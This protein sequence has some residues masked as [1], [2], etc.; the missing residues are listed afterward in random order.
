[1]MMNPMEYEQDENCDY[2]DKVLNKRK[3]MAEGKLCSQCGAKMMAD[4][5]NVVYNSEGSLVQLEK[6]KESK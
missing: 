5:T 3:A 4:G 6:N 2:P 1:M